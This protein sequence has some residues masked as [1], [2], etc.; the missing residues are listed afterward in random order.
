MVR[1]MYDL[2]ITLDD[3]EETL[4]SNSLLVQYVSFFKAFWYT[5]CRL[6]GAKTAPASAG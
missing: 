5:M 6:E 2:I 3:R 1:E 4:G